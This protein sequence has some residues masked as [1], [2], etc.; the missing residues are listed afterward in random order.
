MTALAHR[1]AAFEVRS[2]GQANSR[3]TATR[4]LVLRA[5]DDGWS[6]ITVD[7]EVVFRGLGLRARRECLEFARKLGVLAVHG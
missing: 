5:T 3:D 6:L 1:L 4:R 7:G 2:S